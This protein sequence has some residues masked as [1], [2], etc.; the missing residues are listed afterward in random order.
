MDIRGAK[1]ELMTFFSYDL[2]KEGGRGHRSCPLDPS[3]IPFL[4]PL[5]MDTSFLCFFFYLFYCFLWCFSSLFC[6][7]SGCFSS[8]SLSSSFYS[9]YYPLSLSLLPI[10][11]FSFAFPS[12]FPFSLLYFLRLLYL[13]QCFFLFLHFCYRVSLSVSS[14]LSSLLKLNT[15]FSFSI[16]DLP[17][18]SFPSSCPPLPSS[19]LPSPLILISHI[20][21][22]LTFLFFLFHFVLLPLLDF[23]LSLPFFCYLLTLFYRCLFFPPRF[24]SS[25]PLP[26]PSFLPLLLHPLLNP[27]HFPAC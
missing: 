11:I 26:T 6:V 7:L 15:R 23:P 1:Q 18:S 24:H 13:L 14:F 2:R 17:T 25:Y 9:P 22:L 10:I 8:T 12:S 5:F 27:Y 21:L 20:D 19:S 4:R 3:D 16:S